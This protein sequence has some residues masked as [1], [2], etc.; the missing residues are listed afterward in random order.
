MARGLKRRSERPD[1]WPHRP[2]L[3]IAQDHPC[4]RRAVH[5]GVGSG[6]WPGAGKRTSTT[7][8]ESGRPDRQL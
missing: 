7:T 3:Q 8:S 2:A 5:T 4:R 1:T 6:S